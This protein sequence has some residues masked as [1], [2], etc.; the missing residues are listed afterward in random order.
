MKE[1]FDFN[2]IGKKLPYRIPDS[3][4]D[5]F[6]GEIVREKSLEKRKRAGRSIFWKVSVAAASVVV[7]LLTGMLLDKEQEMP[8]LNVNDTIRTGTVS[9][10]TGNTDMEKI[11]KGLSDEEL[12][13]LSSMLESEMFNE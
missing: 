12:V 2:G 6:S 10:N 11:I 4:L 7:L 5:G 9:E 1:E 3:Y 13:A 8:A